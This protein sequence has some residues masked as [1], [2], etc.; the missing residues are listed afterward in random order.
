[1][2]FSLLLMSVFCIIC[3][4]AQGILAGAGDP[5]KL[6]PPQWGMAHPRLRHPVDVPTQTSDPS[7]RTSFRTVWVVGV[8]QVAALA[9]GVAVDAP[10]RLLYES[11]IG[12]FA[13]ASIGVD[14]VV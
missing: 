5:L 7:R 11:A 14:G 6:T 3:L 4:W 10:C 8:A 1:M 9:S 12:G 2:I 13:R